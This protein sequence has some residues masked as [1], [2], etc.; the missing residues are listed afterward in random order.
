MSDTTTAERLALW[1]L[2][3]SRAPGPLTSAELER[4]DTSDW[5]PNWTPDDECRELRGVLGDGWTIEATENP[6]PDV[7][8]LVVA[9]SDGRRWTIECTVD[10]SERIRGLWFRPAAP[11][12]TII[13]P[14]E[15]DDAPYLA[16]LERRAPIRL[17]DERITYDRG[18][19]Y[20]AKARLMEN[21]TILV[22]LVDGVH[23]GVYWGAVQ[24]VLVGGEPRKLLLEHRV[25]VLPE[26]QKGGVFWTLVGQVRGM[27]HRLVDSIAFYISPR[28]E[29]MVR[30]V[31]D[32]PRWQAEPVRMLLSCADVAGSAAGRAATPDDG[33]HELLNACH[34]RAELYVPYTAESLRSRVTRAPDVYGWERVR[35]HGRAAV[36]VGRDT[37]RLLSERDGDTRESVR[38]TAVD[39][40]FAPGGEDDYVALLRSW[41]AELAGQGVTE[42]AVFTSAGSPTYPLLGELADS[43]EPFWFWSFEISEPSGAPERGFYVDPVYF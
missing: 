42:L 8:E 15:P 13:R 40:G 5:G 11:P 41:C 6:G 30:H 2:E 31:A 1:V 20:F 19:D 38:V 9:G 10:G 12:G 23:A 18:E 17:G 4:F 26:F 33:V 36:G 24:H 14:A 28:N 7:A 25:R 39:H 34:E 32:V 37:L 3:R 43:S 16:D 22:G 21:L 35:V 27:H 29:R